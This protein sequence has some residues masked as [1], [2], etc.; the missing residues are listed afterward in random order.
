[1]TC[2]RAAVATHERDR[3]DGTAS[4][5]AELVRRDLFSH[6]GPLIRPFGPPSPQGEKGRVRR[7]PRQFT[8]SGV[9]LTSLMMI[10][11]RLAS[12]RM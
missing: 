2:G 4:H 1:M 12:S 9:A 10:S 3:D 8:Q 5:S 6:E 11:Q 7:P